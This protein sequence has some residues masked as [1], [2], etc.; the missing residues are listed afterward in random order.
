M[1]G[2]SRRCVQRHKRR[3]QIRQDALLQLVAV[4]K[5]ARVSRKSSWTRAMFDKKIAKARRVVL[6]LRHARKK[7]SF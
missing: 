2:M 3:L 1:V 6:T 5:L 7:I 4:C